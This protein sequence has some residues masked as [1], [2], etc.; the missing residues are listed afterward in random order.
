QMWITTGLETWKDAQFGQ[1]NPYGDKVWCH[2]LNVDN[3][4][5]YDT[6]EANFAMMAQNQGFD[7]EDYR[8]AQDEATN[9]DKYQDAT[10]G[11]PGGN[12]YPTMA[13]KH[14]KGAENDVTHMGWA[15]CRAI[16][17]DGGWT[18]QLEDG[19]EG[20]QGRGSK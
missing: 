5:S 15:I 10:S 12:S 20:W 1:N 8:P 17:E 9:N 14:P 7:W 11:L 19:W 16:P 2:V 4:V 13:F 3:H 6:M 18:W